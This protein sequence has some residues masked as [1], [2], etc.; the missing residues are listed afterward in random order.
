MTAEIETPKPAKVPIADARSA[1]A[2]LEH[3]IVELGQNPPHVNELVNIVK[4]LLTEV[5]KIK[6]HLH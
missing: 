5:E 2:T 4:A 6:G 3:K 1:I